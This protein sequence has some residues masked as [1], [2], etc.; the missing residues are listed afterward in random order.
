MLH[1]IRD[2]KFGSNYSGLC[3]FVLQK[4]WNF[5]INFISPILAN[6]SSKDRVIL[7][8][9]ETLFAKEKKSSVDPTFNLK[10]CAALTHQKILSAPP[11][12]QV[13]VLDLIM[14]FCQKQ[15]LCKL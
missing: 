6:I 1:G 7:V 10:T 4:K 8:K 3:Y 11:Y 13:K 9:N 15:T 2:H 12:P 5:Q 14:T